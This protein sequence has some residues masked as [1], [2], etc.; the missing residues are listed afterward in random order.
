MLDTKINEVIASLDDILRNDH[1]SSTVELGG[2]IVGNIDFR[3]DTDELFER[4]PRLNQIAVY[5][6]ELEIVKDNEKLATEL[7]NNIKYELSKLKTD[8]KSK[9]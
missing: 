5:A 9:H 2:Y 6:E 7:L 3:K 1:N 8:I 4:Y